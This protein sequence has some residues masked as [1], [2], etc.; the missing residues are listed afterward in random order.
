MKDVGRRPRVVF[1]IRSLGI[2]G[3]ERQLIELASGMSEGPWRV[4]VLTFYGGGQLEPDLIARGVRYRPLAKKGRWDIARFWWRLLREV[5]SE[6]P[7]VLHSYL[8]TENL[9]AASLRPFLPRM[10]VVWGLRSSGI[11]LNSYER[12]TAVLGDLEC[13]ASRLAH[14]IISNSQASVDDHARLGFP[15]ERM[16]VVPNGIDAARFTPDAEARQEVRQEWGVEDSTPLVG[17]VGRLDPKK[18]HP[19]FLRAAARVAT[20]RPDVRFVCVGPG[21]DGYRRELLALCTSI[22]LGERVIWAGPRLDMPRVYTA[23]DLLV[24]SSAWG[25]GFPNVVAEAMASGV[26]CV[27]AGSGDSAMVVGDTGWLCRPQDV[28]DL[29]RAIRVALD[30][31]PELRDRGASARQRIVDEFSPARLVERTTA[32]LDTLVGR[33]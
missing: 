4:K 26:P 7:D 22:G 1:L 29:A 19:T 21:P 3:A 6:R 18:D 8:G 9:F 20:E 12:A 15:R 2:G 14:L 30:S 33:A 24:S 10:K 28:E 27:V 13:A 32:L 11:D 23:F 16:K 5:R 31:G 25:E 17:L